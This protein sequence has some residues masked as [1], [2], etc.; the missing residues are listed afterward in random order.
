MMNS[1]LTA[2]LTVRWLR[3]SFSETPLI[4][5]S[6]ELQASRTSCKYADKSTAID[7]LLCSIN[8]A[9]NNFVLNRPL[10]HQ[11]NVGLEDTPKRLASVMIDMESLDD[12]QRAK[13]NKKVNI[14]FS[15]PKILS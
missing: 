1:R 9:G 10:H 6:I 3:Y 14:A 2:D 15:R 8:L 4:T 12:F 11:V 5:Y 7:Q 13:L